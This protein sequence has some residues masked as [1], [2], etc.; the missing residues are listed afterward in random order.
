MVVQE[1]GGGGEVMEVSPLGEVAG[2]GEK[3]VV[4]VVIDDKKTDIGKV[5]GWIIDK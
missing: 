1:H 4:D 2:E 3:T 5:E